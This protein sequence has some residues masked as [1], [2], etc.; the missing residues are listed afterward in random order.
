MTERKE[1]EVGSPSG[2]PSANIVSESLAKQDDDNLASAAAVTNGTGTASDDVTA[3]PMSKNQLKKLKRLQEWEEGR[4][5]RKVKR[6]EKNKE[7]KQRQRL[8]AQTATNDSSADSPKQQYRRNVLVPVTFVIDCGFDDLMTGN[9]RIS[10]ASQVT[11]C[12]ADN[13][14]A[15][16]R[17]HLAVSSFNGE[18]K[19]RFDGLLTGQYKNWAGIRFL[20]EDFAKVGEMAKGWMSGPKRGRT[21]GALA[22][23]GDNKNGSDK[24]GPEIAP[25]GG[26]EVHLEKTSNG[27]PATDSAPTSV[28]VAPE[29]EIKAQADGEVVYLTSDS[30]ET[31]TVLKPYSTYIIGGIVDKN[32]HKGICYKRAV[33]AGIKTARLPIGEFLQ[34]QS[35]QVLTTNH[36]NEIMLKW[37]ELGDWGKAFMAV[38]P[39]RKGGVLK[40]S[41]TPSDATKNNQS[42]DDDDA[43]VLANGDEVGDDAMVTE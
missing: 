4:D 14:K 31:L 36:V 22:A 42:G 34:M 23:Q 40:D 24:T 39:K 30:P 32:R 41:D 6:K 8:A 37:L 13:R 1:G 19:Q 21:V 7:K 15:P 43:E 10:L 3:P 28:Q 35:R 25:S 29:L 17:A 18:L 27:V 20:E 2:E 12:Y 9:E 38:I 11:R 5:A 26:V 16:F 33:E